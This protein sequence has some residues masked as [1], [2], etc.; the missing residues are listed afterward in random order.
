VTPVHQL[1][2]LLSCRLIN[3]IAIELAFSAL[4]IHPLSNV[5][6]SIITCAPNH[7]AI[8]AIFASVSLSLSVQAFILTLAVG[9]DV[10]AF[11]L[12]H[13]VLEETLERSQVVVV[14]D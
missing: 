9:P 11:S 6:V 1:S 5:R 12:A 14:L 10:S 3:F 4:A 8:R 13:V 7:R 2:S